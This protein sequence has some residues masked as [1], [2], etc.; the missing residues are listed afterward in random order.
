MI[1]ITTCIKQVPGTTKVEVDEKTGVLKRDGIESKMNPYDLYA[2]ETALKIKEAQETE[3][4]VVSMGPPQ[5]GEVIREAYM[6]GAD[7]GLL[8]SDRK[9]AGADV[10]ST[11]YTLSQGIAAEALPDLI[12]C[13]KQT[14][15]GDT[16]QVG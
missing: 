8:L 7:K 2:L 6:M 15:D 3:I 12:I 10:L 13:G 14:T 1:R 11:A 9:F 4:T 5:A 16:A